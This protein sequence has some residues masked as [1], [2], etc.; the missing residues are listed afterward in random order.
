MICSRRPPPVA[1]RRRIR[2]I[3]VHALV[4]ILVRAPELIMGNEYV[5]PTRPRD[6]APPLVHVCIIN[7][8]GFEKNGEVVM[9]EK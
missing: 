4:R 2:E 5:S 8:F 1:F 7:G 6:K 9:G 3:S